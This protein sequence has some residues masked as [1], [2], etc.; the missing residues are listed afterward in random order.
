[1]YIRFVDRSND[2]ARV[3]R[4]LGALLLLLLLL[5]LV[6]ALLSPLGIVVGG[7]GRTNGADE[8]YGADEDCVNLLMMRR[9]MA[10]GISRAGESMLVGARGLAANSAD[11]KKRK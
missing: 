11:G 8:E 9:V 1:M 7:G 5:L 4:I 3:E 2:C 6:L 10:G